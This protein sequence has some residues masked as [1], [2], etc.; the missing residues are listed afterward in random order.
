MIASSPVFRAHKEKC[1]AISDGDILSYYLPSLYAS[2]HRSFLSRGRALT[3]GPYLSL[4]EAP[5]GSRNAWISPL[6]DAQLEKRYLYSFLGGSTCMLR[7]RLFRYYRSLSI[8]DALVECTDHYKHWSNES[9]PERS[10]QQRHYIETMKASKFVLCPRGASASSIRMFEAMELGCAPVV[11]ADRWIPVDG[12]D[13]SF[14]IF[15]KEARYR[16]LDAIV[17]S[18]A[19]EWQGRGEAAR[20]TFDTHFGPAAFGDTMERQLRDLLGR[21]DDGRERLIR[22]VYP[23]YRASVQLKGELRMAARNTVLA[24]FRMLGAKFPYDLNK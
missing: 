12:V 1:V 6:K 15:V 11:L 13:W 14:C 20:K 8:P 4:A 2:N 3:A 21:R 17:R 19:S 18:H 9:S 5:L 10:A 7:K 24:G 16:E 22:A 23:L